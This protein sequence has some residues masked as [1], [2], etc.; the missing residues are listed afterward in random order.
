MWVTLTTSFMFPLSVKSDEHPSSTVALA[1]LNFCV[2][3]DAC[4]FLI[5]VVLTS[6]QLLCNLSKMPSCIRA[7]ILT[8]YFFNL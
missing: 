4:C 2:Y 5:F 6:D 3:L 7:I 1:W 8:D